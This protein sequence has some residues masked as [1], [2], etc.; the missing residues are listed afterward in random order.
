MT[1]MSGTWSVLLSL[2]YIQQVNNCPQLFPYI[3][4]SSSCNKR[5]FVAF[6]QIDFWTMQ[7]GQADGLLFFSTHVYPFMLK[8]LSPVQYTLTL[9]KLGFYLGVWNRLPPIQCMIHRQ[10]AGVSIDLPQSI[11]RYQFRDF[12]LPNRNRS[13]FR[14]GDWLTEIEIFIIYQCFRWGY[15]VEAEK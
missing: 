7:S 8:Y 1:S 4:T 12:T 9:K 14:N 2:R 6:F 11:M 10:Y 13:W 15:W 3:S 5:A